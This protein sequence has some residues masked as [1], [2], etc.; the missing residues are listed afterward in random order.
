MPNE[1]PPVECHVSH[2]SFSGDGSVMATVDVHPSAAA[3]GPVACSLKFWDRRTSGASASSG[4]L[5]LLNSHISDPHRC[6]LS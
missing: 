3:S 6:S 2:V 4:P 5:Y 1:P